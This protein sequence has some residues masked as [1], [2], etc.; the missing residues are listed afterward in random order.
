MLFRLP[1]EGPCSE[2]G[3]PLS[4]YNPNFRS[5]LESLIQYQVS[6]QRGR[7]RRVDSA[8]KIQR[9][10][11]II[12]ILPLLSSFISKSR[13]EFRIVHLKNRIG[14][15]P[16]DVTRRAI[17]SKFHDNTSIDCLIL[18]HEGRNVVHFNVTDSPTTAWTDRQI[19]PS[20]P[21]DRAPKHVVRDND[22]I[23]GQ[24]FQKAARN[25]DITEVKIAPLRLQIISSAL[26][27]QGLRD[28]PVFLDSVRLEPSKT[29][30]SLAGGVW[31]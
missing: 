2:L 4:A 23:Y 11:S 17:H 29:P 31:I 28:A 27:S 18:S 9:Y 10:T 21:W 8:G 13:L 3:I 24:E 25:L 15:V 19:T 20:F 6:N 22:K 16:L 26:N 12:G 5:S 30:L 1:A 7:K 14:L